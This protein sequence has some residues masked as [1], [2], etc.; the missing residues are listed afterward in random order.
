[1]MLTDLSGIV[2]IPLTDASPAVITLSGHADRNNTL[3]AEMLTYAQ[4]LKVI[5]GV[6]AQ[7]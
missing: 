4:G 7:A 5:P 6:A 3:V 1:M 2:A